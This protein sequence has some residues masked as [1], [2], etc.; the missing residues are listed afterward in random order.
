MHPAGRTILIALTM[1]VIALV[2]RYNLR[3]N[4]NP[5]NFGTVV[6]GSI[7]RSGWLT[8]A[9]TKAVADA[10]HIKTIIDLG[11]Y[12]GLE[13]EGRAAQQ[14]A[15]ALNIK[16]YTFNLEGDARGDPQD[17]IDALR[18]MSDPKNQPVLVHCSAGSE[19]TSA[20]VMLYRRIF[21]GKYFDET[22]GEAKAHKHVPRKNPYLMEYLQAWG[23][24]IEEAVKSGKDL[25]SPPKEYT[26]ETI[27]P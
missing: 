10:H 8:P 19:R 16:R 20:C 7:Y 23:N 6:E 9:A 26:P 13:A 22:Y 27:T 21:E 1:T 12:R 5:R 18:I 3:D 24:T 2:Y 14:T 25:A 15:D 4:I 17:Y 11:A